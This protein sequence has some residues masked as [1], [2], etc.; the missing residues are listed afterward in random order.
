MPE[1]IIKKITMIPLYC[2]EEI[3]WQ[4]SIEYIDGHK[5]SANSGS[6]TIGGMVEMIDASARYAINPNGAK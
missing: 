4:I 5:E 2:G 1:A 6:C 3:E